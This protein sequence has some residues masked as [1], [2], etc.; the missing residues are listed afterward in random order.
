MLKGVLTPSACKLSFLVSTYFAHTTTLTLQGVGSPLFGTIETFGNPVTL[1]NVRSI[2]SFHRN[3][4]ALDKANYRCSP[5]KI[6]HKQIKSDIID[7]STKWMA[8]SI[9]VQQTISNLL[10]QIEAATPEPT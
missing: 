2:N 1:P 8:T 9:Y 5:T 6:N 10:L 3:L 4:T 7:T